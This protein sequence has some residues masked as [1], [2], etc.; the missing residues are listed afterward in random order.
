MS[1]TI[2]FSDKAYRDISILDAPVQ[3][4]LGIKLK[5]VAAMDSLVSVAT[6]LT[7]GLTGFH[8]IRFGDYRMIITIEDKTIE[9]LRVR[10]RRNVYRQ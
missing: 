7:G 1:Y 6:P 4:R 2:I 8:R 10:H 5:K 3:K 9:V